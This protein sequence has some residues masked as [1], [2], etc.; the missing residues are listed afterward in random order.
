[1]GTLFFATVQ[2]CCGMSASTVV[3]AASAVPGTSTSMFLQEQLMPLVTG[4][5]LGQD[6]G[7]LEEHSLELLKE[8]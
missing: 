2:C 1:M 8:P 6:L 7:I 5:D 4:L 3:T